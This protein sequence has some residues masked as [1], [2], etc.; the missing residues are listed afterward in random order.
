LFGVLLGVGMLGGVPAERSLAQSTGGCSASPECTVLADFEEYPEGGLPLGWYTYQDRK[1]VVRVTG[2]LQN[3]KERFVVVREGTNQF[4]RALVYDQAHRII[5]RNG[6]NM[7]WNIRDNPILR[8][9][10]RAEELPQGAREDKSKLNDSGAAVYV[11]FDKDWLGRPRGIK[12]SYSSSLPIGSTASYGTLR[13][14]VVSSE[15]ED[16]T[17][18]WIAHQRDVAADYE[19][20]FGRRPKGQPSAIF[21]WSDSDSVDGSAVADFDNVQVSVTHCD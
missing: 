3:D 17:G 20:L 18:K 9:E 12:Y 11:L 13:V 1:H 10:W 6:E 2:E 19:A 8:W 15:P 7:E 21:L 4:I 14:L 16:G 5:L